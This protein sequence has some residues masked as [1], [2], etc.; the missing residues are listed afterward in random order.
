[1]L[2]TLTSLYEAVLPKLNIFLGLFEDAQVFRT[3]NINDLIERI[4]ACRD[5]KHLLESW[6][7][8]KTARQKCE[9]KGLLPFVQQFESDVLDSLL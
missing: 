5:N 9:E 8:Y 4:S 7:D 2:S 6:V 1:M 3:L